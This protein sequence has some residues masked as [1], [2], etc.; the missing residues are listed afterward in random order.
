V[1]PN[2]FG[3]DISR[4]EMLNVECAPPPCQRDLIQCPVGEPVKTVINLLDWKATDERSID[5]WLAL[6]WT[7][8]WTT[9]RETDL[10]LAA[11]NGNEVLV[12]R[13]L[14]AKA[15]RP[16]STARDWAVR[17]TRTWYCRDWV[18]PNHGIE[19]MAD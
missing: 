10:M 18:E 7:T 2:T 16:T 19:H 12:R 9:K 11:W 14:E 1:I 5:G 3:Q 6:V 13:L 17:G 8:G 15:D 4:L